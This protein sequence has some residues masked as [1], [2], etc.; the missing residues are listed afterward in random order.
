MSEA[1]FR[2]DFRYV[3]RGLWQGVITKSQF[4]SQAKKVIQR[5]LTNGWNEGAKECGIAPDEL[6]DE[7]VQARDSFVESQVSYLDEFASAIIEQN[8]KKG[9]NVLSFFERAKM[10]LNRYADARNQAKT[11]ACGNSKLEWVIGATGESCRDCLK[12]NGRVYRASVWAKYEIHPQSNRLACHGFRCQ[13]Q[14]RK[15]DKRLTKG[16]PPRMT[17]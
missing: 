16:T 7:E 1:T 8:K 2:T 17:G 12:Y 6:S 15:T 14:L 4:T 5:E 9:G 11:L 13:C 3:V 10:W